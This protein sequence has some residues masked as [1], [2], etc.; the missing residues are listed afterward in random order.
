MHHA[1]TSQHLPYIS[2]TASCSG[3][4]QRD[5]RVMT[6]TTCQLRRRCMHGCSCMPGEAVT[7]ASH[8]ADAARRAWQISMAMGTPRESQCHSAQHWRFSSVADSTTVLWMFFETPADFRCRTGVACLAV[9]EWPSLGVLATHCHAFR[10]ELPYE[11]GFLGFR[12][13]PAYLAV[14]A[15]A[16][17]ISSCWARSCLDRVNV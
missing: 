8:R 12:E 10:T 14:W 9:L 4:K 1:I 6:C 7:A 15:A 3:L 2:K 13:V 5:R 16:Q 11:P 17:V